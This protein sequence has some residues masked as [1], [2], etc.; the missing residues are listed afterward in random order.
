MEASVWRKKQSELDKLGV[1][2]SMHV[3]MA[4][5]LEKS[6]VILWPEVYNMRIMAW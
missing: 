2:G 6:K 4:K 5:D 3:N 1:F